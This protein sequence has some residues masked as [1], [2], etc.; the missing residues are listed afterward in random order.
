MESYEYGCVPVMLSM[1]VRS[2]SQMGDTTEEEDS[3]DQLLRDFRG[4]GVEAIMMEDHQ[5]DLAVNEEGP[6]VHAEEGEGTV[7]QALVMAENWCFGRQSCVNGAHWPPPN[8]WGWQLP[9]M[10]GESPII[11]R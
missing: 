7:E 3:D 5:H 2:E 10:W 4:M 9:N 8:M 1:P 11:G 6:V